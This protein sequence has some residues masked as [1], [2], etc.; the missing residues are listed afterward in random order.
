MVSSGHQ[1][2]WAALTVRPNIWASYLPVPR[3]LAPHFLLPNSTNRTNNNDDNNNTSHCAIYSLLRSWEA[4]FS[5]GEEREAQ[6]GQ[7]SF[8]GHVAG[9]CGASTLSCLQGHPGISPFPPLRSGL[10]PAWVWIP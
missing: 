8:P 3:S 2:S 10:L 5:V 4:G 1:L 9:K 6:R 7:G